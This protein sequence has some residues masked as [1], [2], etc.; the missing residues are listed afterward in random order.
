MR[1]MERMGRMGMMRMRKRSMRRMVRA[2]VRRMASAARLLEHA[3][4]LVLR[5]LL[6]PARVAVRAP[7]QGQG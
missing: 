5:L 2:W 6:P 7:G 4:L 3:V 1:R